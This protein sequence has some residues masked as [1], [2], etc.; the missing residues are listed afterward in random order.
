MHTRTQLGH[1]SGTVVAVTVTKVVC[2][3]ATR[4][5]VAPLGLPARACAGRQHLEP[6]ELMVQQASGAESQKA[7][8]EGAIHFISTATNRAKEKVIF[9]R[10]A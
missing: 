4:A 6:A 3:E 2:M 9:T 1:P 8:Y 7:A 10:S 5:H